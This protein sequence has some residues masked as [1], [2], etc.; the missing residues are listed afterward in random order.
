MPKVSI[1]TITQT[2]NT[3][4]NTLFHPPRIE[5]H[6]QSTVYGTF[7]SPAHRHPTK[8]LQ[9][10]G[11][12]KQL[13]EGTNPGNADARTAVHPPCLK[14]HNQEMVN[15]TLRSELS[16]ARSVAFTSMC[17]MPAV[18]RL[19]HRPP[20]QTASKHYTYQSSILLKTGRSACQVSSAAVSSSH[21]L[22]HPRKLARPTLFASCKYRQDQKSNCG[23]PSGSTRCLLD[24]RYCRTPIIA[25]LC[26]WHL[27]N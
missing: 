15:H 6:Y 19:T 21:I 24:R 3:S 20:R 22:P 13:Y 8:S 23:H 9:R 10:N 17:V 26:C 25:A 12:I 7:A 5:Q 27:M 11:L 18:C 14:L 16:V 2:A 1:N 4:T